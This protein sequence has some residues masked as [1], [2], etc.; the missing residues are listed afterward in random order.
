MASQGVRVSGRGAR[1]GLRVA[2]LAA[3]AGLLAASCGS[4][5]SGSAKGITSTTITIGSH[6][7]LSGVAAPGYDEI[8]PAANAMFSYVND[9]GGINGRKVVYKYQ[10]DVYD[11]SKTSTVVRSLVQQDGVFA[12]FNGLGTPTHLAVRQFLNTSKVPDLFVA[13][14]CL[15]WDD[16]TH[17]PYTFGYQTDYEVE[18]KIMGKYIADHYADKKVGYFYQND[19][20]GKD[21]VKGL[22]AQIP[23]AA[24]ASRQNYTVTQTNIG[25]QIA[26]LQS[27]GAQVVVLYTV[28][29]FT[30]LTLL[31]AAKIGYHPTWVVSDVGSDV[32]TLTGLLQNFSKGQAGSSL[33]NGIISNGYLPSYFDTSNPWIAKFKQIHDQ[34]LPNVPF[35]GNVEYGMS[36]GYSFVRLMQQAGKNPTRDSVINAMKTADL[37]GP[38]LVPF[39][40]SKTSNAGYTGVQMGLITNGKSSLFGPIYQ[41]SDDGPVTEFQ[42]AP[43]QPPANF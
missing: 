37:S 39:R 18:G 42:G 14:G 20:F 29:A 4:S 9:H 12:I 17:F 27:S 35:D 41:A 38:G 22:D 3:I 7:P 19:D 32:V 11:P 16:P 21:G 36:V 10:D 43:T 28:P 2:T 1:R 40:F 24:V 30:A 15:C 25:P 34:Y 13:S 6:Q 23:P 8:A 31:A 5:S 26:Q 33:L